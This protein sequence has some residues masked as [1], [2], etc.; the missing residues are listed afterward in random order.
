MEDDPVLKSLGPVDLAKDDEEIGQWLVAAW[1][2][3]KA[4]KAG[5]ALDSIPKEW[6]TALIK[7]TAEMDSENVGKAALESAFRK[8]CKGDYAAAGRMLRG[9]KTNE[10]EWVVARK[11]ADE[12]LRGRVKLKKM[13]PKGVAAKKEKAAQWQ[14]DCIRDANRMLK[15]GRN[16]REIAGVL[17]ERYEMSATRIRQVL[18]K[19]KIT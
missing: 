7:K 8:A 19:A 12:T 4:K 16:S 11:F 1:V 14:S 15:S 6:A 3:Y 17:A 10:A 5:Y 18:K 2:G 9:L 13:S